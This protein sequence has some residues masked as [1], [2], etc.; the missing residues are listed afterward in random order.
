MPSTNKPVAP[1][2]NTILQ[3]NDRKSYIRI[4]IL[5]LFQIYAGAVYKKDDTQFRRYKKEVLIFHKHKIDL[6]HVRN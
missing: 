3:T 4:K 1:G 6:A 5:S 2:F